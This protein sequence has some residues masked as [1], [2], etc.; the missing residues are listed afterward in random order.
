MSVQTISA[1][2]SLEVQAEIGPLFSPSIMTP[3]VS[4][5]LDNLSV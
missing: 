2:L 1:E 5:D 4:H 3:S